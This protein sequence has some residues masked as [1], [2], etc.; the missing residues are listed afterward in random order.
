MSSSPRDDAVRPIER[1]RH[2]A[3]EH[4]DQVGQRPVAFQCPE[5]MRQVAVLGVQQP[6][7]RAVDT[8]VVQLRP[9]VV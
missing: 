1:N 6:F 3:R 2:A 5:N 8:G 9:L 7:D 4:L